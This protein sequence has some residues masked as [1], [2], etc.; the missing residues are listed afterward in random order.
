MLPDGFP[1]KETVMLLAFLGRT[2]SAARMV[3]A[4]LSTKKEKLAVCRK[5]FLKGM[6]MLYPALITKGPWGLGGRA[7]PKRG[8]VYSPP[9]I[10]VR[11]RVPLVSPRWLGSKK[12]STPTSVPPW[13]PGGALMTFSVWKS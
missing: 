11:V 13:A 2:V 3:K 1:S 12:T 10:D 6:T 8:M 4:G 9:R 7:I 5:M